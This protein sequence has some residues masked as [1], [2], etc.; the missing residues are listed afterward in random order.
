MLEKTKL[1][2]ARERAGMSV[3]AMTDKT[4]TPRVSY[5]RY[6][7]DQRTPD[8]RTAVR[9]AKALGTTVE[10]LW[11]EAPASAQMH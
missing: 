8:A 11:G 4:N 1:Q 3:T 5:Y 7:K 6:E 2:L 9:I 10:T